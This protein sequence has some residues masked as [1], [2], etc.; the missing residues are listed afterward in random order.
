MPDSDLFIG[1]KTKQNLRKL[2]NEG[3]I[4]EHNYN[5]FYKGARSFFTT[6]AEYIIKTYPLKDDL[7]KHAKFV[8]F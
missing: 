3:D 1:F 5:K 2:L 7:L 4:S 6:A 8:N